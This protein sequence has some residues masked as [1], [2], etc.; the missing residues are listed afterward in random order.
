MSED[1]NANAVDNVQSLLPFRAAEND[2]THYR[3]L[4]AASRQIRYVVIAPASDNADLVCYLGYTS[5]NIEERVRYEALSY[6]WGD[7]NDTVPITLRHLDSAYSLSLVDWAIANPTYV[8]QQYSITQNLD[9]A[10][11]NFRL[12]D[13]PRIL[14]VDAISINQNDPI[15]RSAQ[16]AFM[17]SIYNEADRVLVWLGNEDPCSQFVIQ[18]AKVCATEYGFAWNDNSIPQSKLLSELDSARLIDPLAIELYESPLLIK[19]F[20]GFPAYLVLACFTN[21]ELRRALLNI[22]QR[23][24]ASDAP[25]NIPIDPEVFRYTLRYAFDRFYS[26]PWFKRIWVLQEV[27]HARRIGRELQVLLYTGDQSIAF[28]DLFQFQDVIETCLISVCRDFATEFPDKGNISFFYNTWL[29]MW[30]IALWRRDMWEVKDMKILKVLEWTR[31]FQASDVRDKLYAIHGL[32]SDTR[33]AD[34][35]ANYTQSPVTALSEFT[36]W[37]ITHHNNLDILLFCGASETTL[38]IGEKKSLWPASW[39]PELFNPSIEWPFVTD[40]QDWTYNTFISRLSRDG[41]TGTIEIENSLLQVTGVKLTSIRSVNPGTLSSYGITIDDTLLPLFKYI[42]NNIYGKDKEQFDT[43]FQLKLLVMFGENEIG[44]PG[45]I[46]YL[47]LQEHGGVNHHHLQAQT[48]EN[49]REVCDHIDRFCRNRSIFVGQD[50]TPGVGPNSIKEGDIAV[51]LYT[52]VVPYILRPVQ[53]GYLLVGPCLLYD[54][55]EMSDERY[56]PDDDRPLQ[57]FTII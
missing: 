34:L 5:L 37:H 40:R 44:R 4:D 14:W 8:E 49:Y 30:R 18:F 13:R 54:Q 26:R 29:S 7:V 47:A 15:E 22:A 27:F 39:I 35:Q 21:P 56:Q 36:R 16:V 28:G 38:A 24:W 52:G 10:L 48:N 11:R 17:T 31:G 50:G 46:P 2:T 3:P 51:H 1:M 55:R 42:Y 53:D 25:G 20:Y 41:L 57:R 45:V 23:L 6:C 43:A 12:E 32:G 19:M 33:K 9:A